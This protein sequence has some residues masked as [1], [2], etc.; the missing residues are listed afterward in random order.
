MNPFFTSLIGWNELDNG[1]GLEHQYDPEKFSDAWGYIPTETSYGISR[2]NVFDFS[3]FSYVDGW[4]WTP[5]ALEKFLN[6]KSGSPKKV[7]VALRYREFF[8]GIKKSDSWVLT[9]PAKITYNEWLSLLRCPRH[10]Q[11]IPSVV[12]QMDR[13][14]FQR[15]L[16]N[17]TPKDFDLALARARSL[18]VV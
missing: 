11:I 13:I 18:G 2:L 9:G 7:L 15:F 6:V 14:N 3:E 5:K 1:A 16:E 17:A 8:F 12:T 4:T 10:Q